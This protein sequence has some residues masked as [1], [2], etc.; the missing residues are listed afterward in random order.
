RARRGAGEPRWGRGEREPLEDPP[1]RLQPAAQ[2][3]GRHADLRLG[4]GHRESPPQLRRTPWIIPGAS[5]C[6]P[7][8]LPCAG[9]RGRASRKWLA[10]SD[11][12]ESMGFLVFPTSAVRESYLDGERAM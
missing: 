8:K 6:A 5:S 4:N 11:R 10:G 7:T 2:G 9:A 1:A 3:A 12:A